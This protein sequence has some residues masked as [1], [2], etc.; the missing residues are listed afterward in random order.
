MLRL[1]FYLLPGSRT[2]LPFNKGSYGSGRQLRTVFDET[3]IYLLTGM[4]D[5][6]LRGFYYYLLYLVIILVGNM[7]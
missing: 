7:S 3:A 4:D 5:Q 2:F 1:F 6:Q